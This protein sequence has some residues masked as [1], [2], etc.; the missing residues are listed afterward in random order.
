MLTSLHIENLAVV[1]QADLSLSDGFTVLTGETGAGKSMILDAIHLLLGERADKDQVRTGATKALVGGMFE[2][3][4]KET[5]A[6]LAS[7]GVEADADGVLYLQRTVDADGKS[8]TLLNGRPIP[9]SLQKEIGVR[10]INI[11]GQH[12]SY[13][14]LSPARHKDFL[15]RYAANAELLLAYRDC[16]TAYTDLCRQIE[17]CRCDEREKER[18]SAMLKAQIEEIDSAKLKD[19]EEELL[20]KKRTQIRNAEKMQKQSRTVYRA[21]YQNEKGASAYEFLTIAQKAIA[22]IAPYLDDAE[23]LNARLAQCQSELMDIAVRVQDAAGENGDDPSLL[24][25]RIESRLELFRILQRKYGAT[26][27]DVLNYRDDAKRQ[28][29]E[30]ENQEARLEDLTHQKKEIETALRHQAQILHE[31]REKA[32]KAMSEAVMAELAF[33]E[34]GKVRFA[35]AVNKT[36]DVQNYTKDGCDQIEFMVATNTAEP[37]RPLA[38]IASGGELSRIMLAMKCVLAG[39]DGVPT[40]IFDEIDTGVSGKTSQKVGKKL[41][42]TAKNAQVLCVTH[43]AQIASLAKTHIFVSKSDVDGRTETALTYLEG[44]ARVDALAAMMGGATITDSVKKAAK[45]LLA[46]ES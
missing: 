28:L 3:L 24:L 8:K 34:M 25:D 13:A 44:D 18:K 33:L 6:E 4:S 12:D 27:T 39:A 31:N 16:Y 9:Q 40:L 41:R 38:K 23:S 46:T 11:H 21:L 15:D 20:L 17:D 2:H 42:Q 22:Q 30:M 37:L 36:E 10:L 5:T 14:L 19:G 26:N 43:A 32:A 35:V 29:D 7:L 1:K 45:E